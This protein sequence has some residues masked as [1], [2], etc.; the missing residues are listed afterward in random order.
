MSLETTSCWSFKKD[1][2][3]LQNPSLRAAST[4][5]SHSHSQ[6][7]QKKLLKNFLFEKALAELLITMRFKKNPSLPSIGKQKILRKKKTH[8]NKTKQNCWW[9]WI[10]LF[11]V[12]Q[13][14]PKKKTNPW[15]LYKRVF[16]WKNYTKVARFWGKTKAESGQILDK[17]ELFAPSRLPEV[18]RI[19][20]I[21]Y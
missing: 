11:W 16:L 14:W 6:L 1:N 7:K 21:F 20:K 18:A 9:W 17:S 8:K 12:L 3:S 15:E 2:S 10:I 5:H 13:W 4:N 19:P